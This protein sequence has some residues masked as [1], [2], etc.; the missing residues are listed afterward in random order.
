MSGQYARTHPW[1]GVDPARLPF[2]KADQFSDGYADS[3]K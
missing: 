3:G 1:S 2:M